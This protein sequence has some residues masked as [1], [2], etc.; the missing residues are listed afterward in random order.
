MSYLT[1]KRSIALCLAAVAKL[2]NFLSLLMSLHES[3]KTGRTFS[4]FLTN[5]TLPIFMNLTLTLRADFFLRV[6][7]ASFC[8]VIERLQI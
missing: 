7:V 8:K 5:S 6:Q 1:Y 3:S 2:T 4:M